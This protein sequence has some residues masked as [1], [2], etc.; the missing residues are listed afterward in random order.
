MAGSGTDGAGGG[1]DPSLFSST[2]SS[3]SSSSS[4]SERVGIRLFKTDEGD[5]GL[6]AGAGEGGDEILLGVFCGVV[7]SSGSGQCWSPLLPNPKPVSPRPLDS[8]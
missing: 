6:V 5:R 7:L 3:S 4:S 8:L 2:S 1:T